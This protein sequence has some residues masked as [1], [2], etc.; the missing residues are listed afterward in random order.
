MTHIIN[1]I[2]YAH[3]LPLYN[4]NFKSLLFGA[5]ILIYFQKK[6]KKIRQEP[7][8]TSMKTDIPA[9]TLTLVKVSKEDVSCLSMLGV[10]ELGAAELYP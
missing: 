8:P 6:K 2:L 1:W 10:Q 4:S 7:Q 3:S 5:D 9:P